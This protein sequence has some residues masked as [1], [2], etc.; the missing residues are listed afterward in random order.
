[1]SAITIGQGYRTPTP[2]TKNP[3]ATLAEKIPN[4]LSLSIETNKIPPD[5]WHVG[6]GSLDYDNRGQLLD[7]Y[8]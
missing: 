7:V 6:K 3:Q 1:M 8:A 4:R 5:S 2:I